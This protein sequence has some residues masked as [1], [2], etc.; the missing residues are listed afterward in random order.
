MKLYNIAKHY[1]QYTNDSTTTEQ[2][3]WFLE[4]C[5]EGRIHLDQV[6]EVL[7][8]LKEW[9]KWGCGNWN[10]Y[11]TQKLNKRVKYVKK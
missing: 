4:H 1:Q 2:F 3:G 5:G 6:G 7:A 8:A 9:R 11:V 10:N